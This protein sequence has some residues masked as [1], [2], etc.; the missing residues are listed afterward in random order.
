M[1]ASATLNDQHVPQDCR[2]LW[3]LSSSHGPASVHLR[4]GPGTYILGSAVDA[5]LRLQHPTVSRRHAR[6]TCNDHGVT[7]ED[8]GSV[9]GTGIE[10][11]RIDC[12]VNLSAE[13]T[14]NFGEVEVIF[15]STD[16][17]GVATPQPR[18]PEGERD[19]ELLGPSTIGFLRSEGL[20]MEFDRGE[21]IIRRGQSQNSFY[22]VL[23]GEVEIYLE[24]GKAHRRPLAQ[25]GAGA[26]F[27][28]ESMLAGEGA[29]VDAVALSE[30]RLLQYPASAVDTALRDSASLRSKLLGG[31]ARHLHQATDD[32]LDLLK[33]TEVIT[34]LVQGDDESVHLVAVSARMRAIKNRIERCASVRSPVL[35]LGEPGTGKTLAARLIHEASVRSNGPLIAVSCRKLNPEDAAEL[36][37]GATNLR[38]SDSDVGGSGGVHFADGGTLIL[39]DLD[40]LPDA[41]QDVVAS[42]LSRV[43]SSSAGAFPN[44]RIVATT[45]SSSGDT[46]GG[47]GLSPKLMK[48]FR[49]VVRL[50]SL[51]DRPKDILPLAE[52]MLDRSSREPPRLTETAC[53]ALVAMPFRR[54]NVA[55]LRE[56]L[57][58]AA[59]IS[60][61]QEIRAEHILGGAGEEGAVPGVD[62]IGS[63]LVSFI[64]RSVV[65]RLLRISS[66][67]GY[68][69]V[70][71]LC[72]VFASTTLGLVA[73]SAIWAVWEPVVFGLFLLVG[74]IWCTICPLSVVGRAVKRVKSL[75]RPVPDWMVVHG[76]WLTIV[77][78]VAI[79]GSER[80]F[81]MTKNPIPSGVMLA[82]LVAAA[83]F[84]GVIYRREVWCRHLCPLGRLAVALA[85]ASPLQLTAQRSICV[86]SCQTHE[87]YK[88]TLTIPGC[89]VYH[90][91]LETAQ[92]HHCKLCMDC[93]HSCPHGSV[94]IEA[95]APLRAIWN[96]DTNSSGVALFG[97]AVSLLALALLLPVRFPDCA[98]PVPFTIACLLSVLAGVG[99]RRAVGGLIGAGH[100]DAE[101]VTQ[102][103]FGLMILGW[104]VL[105]MSQLAN[106]PVLAGS[107]IVLSRSEL[108]LTWAPTGLAGLVVVQLMVLAATTAAALFTLRHIRLVA[109]TSRDAPSM[110]RWR[111]VQLVFVVYAAVA[112]FLIV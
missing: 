43:Q 101:G 45:R 77:G 35:V 100:R 42:Y 79:V 110:V 9:N 20:E 13:T 81:H 85:P 38:E 48:C 106:I 105:M 64:S 92:A 11:Q 76:P 33:G 40:T 7:I 59:R 60:D 80:V 98:K 103:G 29:A 25:L 22:V 44:T 104:G 108:M 15:G 67:V 37:L 27:G 4:F 112:V 41:V 74:P 57:D 72:L 8:L 28:A 97:Y 61:N 51:A 95:R 17:D 99:L 21:V 71:L 30:V 39:R 16:P 62:L 75:C 2:D 63:P 58:L 87:C 18:E 109:A 34:R 90:H 53:H 10:G 107:R 1:L 6:I 31:M 49:D 88:G 50:P 93:L 36:I 91:P 86:S 3:L 69:V 89:T 84:F 24:E 66:V 19:A 23:D 52:A 65:L 96:L 68:G 26:T 54:N 14:I 56:V 46:E 82:T 12:E 94:R 102:V 83:V 55:E 5:D 111:V 70:I 73:N 32:A 78:F 47:A